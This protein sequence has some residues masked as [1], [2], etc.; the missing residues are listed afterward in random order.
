MSC[1]LPPELPPAPSS[2]PW[3]GKVQ[4]PDFRLQPLIFFISLNFLEIYTIK[5]SSLSTW[6]TRPVWISWIWQ[7]YRSL[8]KF[9]VNI[10]I[11]VKYYPKY[12]HYSWTF[13]FVISAQD[14][15][16]SSQYWP[17]IVC[18]SDCVQCGVSFASSP[19][20]IRHMNWKQKFYWKRLRVR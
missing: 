11:A 16:I 6:A 10:V 9:L 1:F 3:G 5:I 13:F 19:P 2:L 7:R 14:T 8:Y 17:G 12:L 18:S 20:L 15:M 4:N